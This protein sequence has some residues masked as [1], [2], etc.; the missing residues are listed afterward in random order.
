MPGI[1]NYQ[2]DQ[3]ILAVPAAS[4]TS[5]I[6]KPELIPFTGTI[7]KE[8]ALTRVAR[9]YI[10]N[11]MHS[12]VNSAYI[13]LVGTLDLAVPPAG[14]PVPSTVYYLVPRPDQP[15]QVLD[16]YSVVTAA[17]SGLWYYTGAAPEVTKQIV[18]S[19]YTTTINRS[20][21]V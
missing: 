8:S 6:T 3:Y 14:A 1:N 11:T 12:S 16:L 18:H 9:S 20:A 15:D 4:D 19:F 2:F 21:R 10:R 7:P 13:T 17:P 5:S